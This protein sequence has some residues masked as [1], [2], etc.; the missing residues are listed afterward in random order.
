MLD[1]RMGSV[2]RCTRGCTVYA[3][4][5]C[6]RLE[7]FGLYRKPSHTVERTLESSADVDLRCERDIANPTHDEHTS[8]SSRNKV[9]VANGHERDRYL[10][11][12]HIMFI[13]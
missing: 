4:R 8:C 7:P 13:T 11:S 1:A 6:S 10:H 2:V 5:S 9:V 3:C 12:V